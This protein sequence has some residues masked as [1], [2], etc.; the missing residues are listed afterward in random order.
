[1]IRVTSFHTEENLWRDRYVKELKRLI[2]FEWKQVAIKRC[3]SEATKLLL[4]EEQKFL[5][6]H[7]RFFV[8]SPRGKLMTDL[9]FYH[10]LFKEADRHLVVG[11]A[12]GFS[13]S[14]EKEAEGSLSLSPLTLTHA[15]AQTVLA[16]SL[17]R[18]VCRL[19]N[20]PF[21]K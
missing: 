17:Y 2:P 8:L 9:E 5:K 6:D 4:P 19:K 13:E 14:F 10:W 12:I 3:P 15:L 1:M 21:V 16:E 11:P 18:A 7:K 20:H